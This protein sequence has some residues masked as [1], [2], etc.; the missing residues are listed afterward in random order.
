M[1]VIFIFIK[2]IA[3]TRII[4][5]TIVYSH[6]NTLKLRVRSKSYD[7][8]MSNLLNPKVPSLNAT[9]TLLKR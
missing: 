8:A 2:I 1:I 5:V 6:L 4:I 7:L 9:P 3:S